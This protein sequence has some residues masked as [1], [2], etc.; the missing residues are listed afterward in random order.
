MRDELQA[1][2]P[3]VYELMRDLQRR[4]AEAE[5]AC[6]ADMERLKAHDASR[7]AL[8]ERYGRLK[9]EVAP[10]RQH[11]YSMTKALAETMSYQ[12]R[13]FYVGTG[14][15]LTFETADISDATK[16]SA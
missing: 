9:D 11:I 10:M 15:G 5:A 3:L 16:W 12:P 1:K 7:E 13:M 6:M 4:I 14:E 8:N 2:Y